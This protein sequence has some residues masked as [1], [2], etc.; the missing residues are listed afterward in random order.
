[1]FRNNI[2]WYPREYDSLLGIIFLGYQG[3]PEI[4]RQEFFAQNKVTAEAS[5]RK[6]YSCERL[7]LEQFAQNSFPLTSI[8][9]IEIS[10]HFL[11]L[12]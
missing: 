2:P 1:M 10:F 5:S 7:S 12:V 6:K 4:F 9:S 11:R 3:I 8:D